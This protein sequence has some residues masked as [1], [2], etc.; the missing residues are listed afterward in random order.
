MGLRLDTAVNTG[1]FDSV[2]YQDIRITGMR[3]DLQRDTIRVFYEQGNFD[4]VTG[5]FTPGFEPVKEFLI[6][7]QPGGDQDYTTFFDEAFK[8]GTDTV[9]ERFVE[10][11]TNLLSL[12]LGLPGATIKPGRSGRR[13]I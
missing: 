13:V 8:V 4:D 1:D 2:D 6:I 9:A 12:R 5:A 7:D 3:W 11:A 10:M